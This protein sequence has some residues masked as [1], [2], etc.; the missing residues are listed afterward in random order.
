M[1]KKL[2]EIVGIVKTELAK[3][4]GH[5]LVEIISRGRFEDPGQSSIGNFTPGVK[6]IKGGFLFR[7]WAKKWRKKGRGVALR[8][9]IR[10]LLGTMAR[11]PQSFI[12]PFDKV[13]RLRYSPHPPCADPP[14]EDTIN[15]IP[16]L[17]AL[18]LS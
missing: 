9:R 18:Q 2:T 7:G 13:T 6:L 17:D 3:L 10:H 5:G 12:P 11:F 4:A 14:V 15:E 16:L 8:H 1:V